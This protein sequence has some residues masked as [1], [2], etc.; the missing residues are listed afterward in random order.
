MKK[1]NFDFE[2]DFFR[3]QGIKKRL[4]NSLFK[5]AIIIYKEEKS[6]PRAL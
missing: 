2:L 1:L 6:F 5:L 3:R 4:E